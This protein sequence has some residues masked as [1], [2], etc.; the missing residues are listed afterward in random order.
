MSTLVSAPVVKAAVEAIN[1]G[2][3]DA[4]VERL[5]PFAVLVVDAVP[6]DLGKWIDDEI[7]GVNGRVTVEREDGPRLSVRL[8]GVAMEWEFTLRDGRIGKLDVRRAA[9]G[10]GVPSARTDH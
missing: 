10:T 7:F 9:T 5:A 8:R 2:D 1:F 3:R 6:R 4:F